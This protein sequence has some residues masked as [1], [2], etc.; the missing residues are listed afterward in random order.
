MSPR[1]RDARIAFAHVESRPDVAPGPVQ[2]I[3][4]G[5]N[6][7]WHREALRRSFV[8]GTTIERYGRVWRMGQAR[9]RE[10]IVIGRI[11]YERLGELAE[12]WDEQRKDF[13]ETQLPEGLTSPFALN[14]LT[15]RVA[16]QLRAGRIEPN[17]FTGAFRA[18]LN[19]GIGL[20]LW[21][22]DLA[23]REINWSRWRE[24][25]KRIRY[26]EVRVE[27]PNPNYH[28]RDEIER[29]VEGTNAQL[30][31]MIFDAGDEHGGL[32]ID[33]PLIREAIEHA[34][35]EHGTVKAVGQPGIGAERES[36]WRS[37]K[38]GAPVETR[39]P[40]DPAT[41]EVESRALEKEVKEPS[42]VAPTNV[43][44]AERRAI[45]SGDDDDNGDDD[46]DT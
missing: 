37:D 46:S 10:N 19:E 39:A 6:G 23:V 36:V 17:S 13:K 31:K 3:A 12:L 16:F 40:V 27:R 30:V 9:R 15:G 22:V 35:D 2:M 26:V 11:G 44:A 14:L 45:T 4:A 5:R 42:T 25:V 8:A 21:R 38:E 20:P 1:W 34:L 33:D 24:S 41:R 7:D 43:P 32:N 28:G 29:I 18:L